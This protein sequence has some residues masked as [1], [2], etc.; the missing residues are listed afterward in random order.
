MC[1]PRSACVRNYVLRLLQ[2]CEGV[3]VRVRM[4][5]CVYVCVRLGLALVSIYL[6]CL[7]LLVFVRRSQAAMLT[8]LLS[9]PL[10]CAIFSAPLSLTCS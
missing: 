2:V 10:L 5:E 9:L 8:Y 4:C 6:S 1:Q 3:C 7:S